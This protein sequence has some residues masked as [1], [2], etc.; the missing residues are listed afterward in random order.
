M[1]K[2]YWSGYRIKVPA[3]SYKLQF[4]TLF[5]A[6]FGI[7][8]FNQ[9]FHCVIVTWIYKCFNFV[10]TWIYTMHNSGKNLSLIINSAALIVVRK[11]YAFC[12]L[13][14]LSSSD[15]HSELIKLHIQTL[16]HDI[17]N[18]SKYYKNLF[19]QWI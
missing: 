18:S 11:M 16:K 17:R 1:Y 9:T 6:S 19:W 10:N 7:S 5:N 15:L 14:L 8:S 12:E 13:V 2:I 4:I 3:G